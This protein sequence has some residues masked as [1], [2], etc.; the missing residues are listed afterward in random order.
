MKKT[1]IKKSSAQGVTNTT[2]NV[3]LNKQ[4]LFYYK[5]LGFY[6]YNIKTISKFFSISLHRYSLINMNINEVA[7]KLNSFNSVIIDNDKK[8]SMRISLEDLTLLEDLS[9][10][11]GL[12]M[13]DCLRK[14]IY[15]EVLE[16]FML[17]PKAPKDFQNSKESID[18]FVKFNFRYNED[19]LKL[20]FE[21]Y[22]QNTGEKNLTAALNDIAKNFIKN[23]KR[24]S[25]EL[26]IKLSE[27]SPCNINNDFKYNFSMA[28]NRYIDFKAR[29]EDI[30]ISYQEGL[31]KAIRIYI[32]EHSSDNGD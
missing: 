30:G 28:R 11:M 3:R 14:I 21:L 10:G 25:K 27:K 6:K 7:L 18:S 4:F 1:T 5:T 17:A 31:R 15:L 23:S 19:T 20:F 22:S 13:S 24:N 29:C 26:V 12:K 9:K 32:D 2:I 8:F 16:S